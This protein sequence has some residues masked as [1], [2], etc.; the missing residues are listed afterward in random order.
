MLDLIGFVKFGHLKVMLSIS[1][2]DIMSASYLKYFNEHDEH[3]IRLED[4]KSAFIMLSIGLCV[5]CFA[6]MMEALNWF[7]FTL[8][9]LLSQFHKIISSFV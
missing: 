6:L 4:Y 8:F 5:S 9:S 7:M 2:E 3:I 1:G